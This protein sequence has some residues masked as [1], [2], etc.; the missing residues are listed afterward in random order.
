MDREGK[1]RKEEVGLSSWPMSNSYPVTATNAHMEARKMLRMMT[2]KETKVVLKTETGAEEEE[3][4]NTEETKLS[5][6]ANAL[7]SLCSDSLV[8]KSSPSPLVSVQGSGVIVLCLLVSQLV[9][10]D[11]SDC[12]N[13]ADSVSL[14]M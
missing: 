4:D 8:P 11:D 10:P 13:R 6:I 12:G 3:I 5:G 1:E 9:Q 7:A 14:F 2:K